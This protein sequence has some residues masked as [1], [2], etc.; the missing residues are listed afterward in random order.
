MCR[1]HNTRLLMQQSVVLSKGGNMSRPAPAPRLELACGFAHALAV[2]A[3]D[4]IDQAVCVVE[5]V[6]PQR[7][8]LLLAAHVPDGEEHVLVLHLLHV[9]ACAAGAPLGWR[10]AGRG[11]RAGAA[12]D[13]SRGPRAGRIG[14]PMVG[15]VLKISPMC[16]LYRMVVFPAASRPSITTCT[17][18][19]ALRQLPSARRSCRGAAGGRRQQRRTRISLLPKSLSISL[20]IELPMTGSP[21]GRGL[22][23]FYSS[24][25]SASAP[26]TRPQRCSCGSLSF[27][28][29]LSQG[30]SEYAGVLRFLLLAA[31]TQG[32]AYHVRWNN[33]LLVAEAPGCTATLLS[34][35]K[36]CGEQA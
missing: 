35:R 8:Q 13:L 19:A 28:L 15:T 12:S 9:E 16:S 5:V 4:D 27:S 32:L 33:A 1:G 36:A 23:P 21:P 18:P 17:T 34:R 26:L 31:P 6:A 30:Q 10:R 29:C 11:S 3:V 7:P 22:S 25:A 2:L 14:A 24:S 20:R